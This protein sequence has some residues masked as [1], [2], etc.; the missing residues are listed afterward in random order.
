MLEELQ[1][2]FEQAGGLVEERRDRQLGKQPRGPRRPP[3]GSRSGCALA[4]IAL[5]STLNTRCWWRS[6][7]AGGTP[8]TRCAAARSARDVVEAQ[9]DLICRFLPDTT[10]TFVN[11]AYARFLK[12]PADELIGVRVVDLVPAVRRDAFRQHIAALLESP[13]SR[14][15][16]SRVMRDDGSVDCWIEWVNSTPARTRRP[17]RRADRHRTRHHRSQARG[18]VAAP[19]RRA[20]RR[21]PARDA[22]S[23]VRDEP[24]RRLPGLS[25]ARPARP[26]RA[27]GAVP[28]QDGVRRHAAGAVHVVR[29][30]HRQN[31]RQRRTGGGRST[32]CRWRAASASSRRASSARDP[33]RS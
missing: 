24:R 21:H 12:K 14:R 19:E 32:R 15:Y 18:S 23:D 3:H 30:C 10:L 1:G 33:A 31:G 4:I 17:R 5:Q 2:L 20:Q 7:A 16:E 26:V 22:G 9:T 6:A 11:E 8:S 29:R 28:R 25:R 13:G 27:A